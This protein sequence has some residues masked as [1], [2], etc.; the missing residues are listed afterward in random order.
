M[1]HRGLFLLKGFRQTPTETYIYYFSFSISMSYDVTREDGSIGRWK[2]KFYYDEQQEFSR[3]YAKHITEEAIRELFRHLVEKFSVANTK[4]T[5]V[6]RM[7]N[8]SFKW[9]KYVENE[10][11]VGNETRL[12]VVIHEVAHAIDYQERDTTKHD[13][14]MYNIMRMVMQY[15]DTTLKLL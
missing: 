6:P 2:L 15:A 1:S 11:K 3:H 4:L 9:N 5:I 8:G 7:R 10:I 12:G 14:Y 13:K